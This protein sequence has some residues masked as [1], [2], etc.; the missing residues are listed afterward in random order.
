MLKNIEGK[1]IDLIAADRAYM[2]IKSFAGKL[3]RKR[4][5]LAGLVGLSKNEERFDGERVFA[6][7]REVDES[8]A[9]GLREGVDLFSKRHPEYG[10]I[11][12][13]IIEET[14]KQHEVHLY[15]GTLP[16]KT[17]TREDYV[18]VM[19]NLG[20]SQHSAERFYPIVMEITRSIQKQRKGNGKDLRSIM[21]G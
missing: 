21:I 1:I 9:R 17:L 14:R 11:L 7:V 6:Y 19:M 2:P 12:N 15:F 10:E 20:L 5:K 8:K 3:D 13:G 18:G 4:P 16:N